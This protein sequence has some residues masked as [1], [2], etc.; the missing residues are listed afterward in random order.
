[1]SELMPYVPI[2]VML[3]FMFLVLVPATLRMKKRELAITCRQCGHKKAR[4]I[5]G[6]MCV[7]CRCPQYIQREVA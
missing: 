3:A 4:H 5:D 7:L 2:L 6:G 1:M